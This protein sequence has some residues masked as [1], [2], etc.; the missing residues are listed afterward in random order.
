VPD[1][2]R[3]ERPGPF[4]R[5][6]QGLLIVL[7]GI[8]PL[9]LLEGGLRLAGWPTER[10]RTFG[11]LLIFDEAEWDAS[12]GVFRPGADATVMWPPELSYRVHVNALGFRGPEIARTP[13]PGRTRILALGDSHTF[14]YYLEDDETW[15]ARLEAQLRAAGADV[16]VV[17]AGCGG[18]SI[19]SQALFALERG[20]AIAPDRVV[21]AY[22]GN[23][24]ADLERGE[25]LY[26]SQ[27]RALLGWRAKLT[28]LVYTS[29]SYEL[30]LR[31]QVALKQARREGASG[32]G[33]DAFEAASGARDLHDPESASD[34]APLWAEYETWLARLQAG[35]A[36]RGIGLSVVYVPNALEIVD[37]APGP[38]EA[39]LRA[40]TERLGLPL[41][42]PREAFYAARDAKLFH[43]PIDPHLAEDGARLV[44]EAAARTLD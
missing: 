32:S 7:L 13:P 2:R 31:A 10:V 21:V 37:G 33:S 44:A 25:P 39:A 23:D 14:G 19:D 20:L 41:A 22:F 29:A 5:T 35:L 34:P 40:I 3:G 24:L 28:R 43:L 4:S 1:E 42:S 27:Q 18:W 11:K 38:E 16:E 17:N 26:V 8:A 6:L 15:P 9:A 12:V 30:Y 36:V